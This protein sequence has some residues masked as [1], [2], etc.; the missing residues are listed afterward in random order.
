MRSVD[1]PTIS[2]VIPTISRPSL[3][4]TLAS[5]KRQDWMAGDEVILVADGPQPIARELWNQFGLCGRFIEVAGPSR[6]WGHGPRN[7][8]N[9]MATGSHIMNLDDDDELAPNAVTIVRRSIAKDPNRPHIFRMSGHPVVGT[10]WKDPILFQGNVGTP[11][12]VVPN[13]HG[14]VGKF[15]EHRYAGDFDYAYETCG[16]YPEGPIWNEEVICLVRPTY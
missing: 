14:K 8:V 15:N 3:A 9:P 12:I 1:S 11:M 10:A 13:I 7:K 2:L 5:V 6:N 4:R 16:H